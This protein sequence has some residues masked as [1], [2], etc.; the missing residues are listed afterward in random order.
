MSAVCVIPA[1]GGSQRVP[2]KNR[3]RFHGKPIICYSI[4]C[5]QASGVFEAIYVSTDDDDIETIAR[6]HGAGI[7]RRERDDGSRG[8]QE[9]MAE[10]IEV[11]RKIGKCYDFACCLYPTAPM[12]EPQTLRDAHSV[13]MQSGAD[14]VVPVA[15][16]L[17]DPGQFYF[18]LSDAFRFG[19]P[20]NTTGTRLLSIDPRTEC[21][22]NTPEDF[23]RAERMYQLLKEGK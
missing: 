3:R 18:G 9:V 14:Y 8:T 7:I 15:A 20:L 23:L 21:D 2:N 13:L 11:L 19:V 1:R 12:L 10:A 4:E 5:A 6:R 16:W 22:I 17:R